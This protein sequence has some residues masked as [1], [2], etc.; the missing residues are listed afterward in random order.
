MAA[1]PLSRRHAGA[2]PLLIRIA[3][4]TALPLF[5]AATILGTFSGYEI[6]VAAGWLALAV[7]ED[8]W[9][10]AAGLHSHVV[11]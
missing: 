7:S 8:R 1:T 3:L 10:E 4:A 5:A 6:I 2:Q 9:G 11:A